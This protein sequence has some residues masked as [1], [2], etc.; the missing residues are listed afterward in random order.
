M[1]LVAVSRRDPVLLARVQQE[2]GFQHALTDYRELLALDLD[3]VVVSSPHA[4]HRTSTPW[5]RCGAACMS[6][7]RS[8]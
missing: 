7:A 4:A 1:E 8:R 5:R 6:C 3:G 2:F